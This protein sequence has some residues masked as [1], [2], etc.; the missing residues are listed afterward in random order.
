MKA[1]TRKLRV[2]ENNVINDKPDP[3]DTYMGTNNKKEQ[4]LF[5]VAHKIVE[6]QKQQLQTVKEQQKANPKVDYTAK[7]E[8][9]LELS[10]EAEAIVSQAEHIS[11]HRAMHIFETAIACRHH[12]NDPQDKI[13]FYLRFFWFL[14]EIQDMLHHSAIENKIMSSP[15]FFDLCVDEQNKKL[16]ACY[17]SWREWFSKESF[18]QWLKTHPITSPNPKSRE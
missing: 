11:I 4:E 2:L 9:V 12:L 1:L 7:I 15:G 8:A 5:R 18:N 10:D 14:S 3:E 6:E 16:N 13:I 17:D